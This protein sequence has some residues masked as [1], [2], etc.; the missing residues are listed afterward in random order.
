MKSGMN[1]FDFSVINWMNCIW[2]S[3]L[4]PYCKYLAAY[5]RKFMNDEQDIAWP[6]YA[7]IIHETGLSRAT[8]A[9]YLGVLEQSEWIIRDHETRNNTTYIATLPKVVFNGLKIMNMAIESGSTS[10]E[11][12]RQLNQS[13]TPAK[14]EVVRELNT[15]KQVNKQ[16]SKPI[17]N[18]AKKKSHS[19]PQEWL[20]NEKHAESCL[21]KGLLINDLVEHFRDHHISKGSKMV[22]W[23]AAFRNWI[24]NAVKFN[25][26]TTQQSI[27]Q[28]DTSWANNMQPAYLPNQQKALGHE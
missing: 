19:I 25:K 7:R 12:V 28:D 11:L 9:K 21:E 18:N 24:R 15:N 10:D 4:P 26:P 14:P 3:K 20:P 8:V 22:D 6:S 13:S 2:K 16:T 5:L 27:Q 1:S 23:D 17:I